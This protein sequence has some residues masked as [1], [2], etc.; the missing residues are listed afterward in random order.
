VSSKVVITEVYCYQLWQCTP[1]LCVLCSKSLT[2]LTAARTVIG[3]KYC[4]A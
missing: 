1:P 4:F 3:R 2:F